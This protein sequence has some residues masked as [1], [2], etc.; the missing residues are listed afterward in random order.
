LRWIKRSGSSRSLRGYCRGRGLEH[1]RPK[2]KKNDSKGA[3][4]KNLTS[5]DSSIL[6]KSGR[7]LVNASD[8]DAQRDGQTRRNRKSK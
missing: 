7:R 8:P 3:K 1:G 6:A 5:R 2:K 4:K